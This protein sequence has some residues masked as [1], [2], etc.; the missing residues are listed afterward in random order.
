MS[1][2][3]CFLVEEAISPQSFT[4]KINGEDFKAD[5]FGS[6]ANI[7]EGDNGDYQVIIGGRDIRN[8]AAGTAQIIVMSF[9]GNSFSDLRDGQSFQAYDLNTEKGVQ[10]YFFDTTDTDDAIMFGSLFN[11]LGDIGVYEDIS[12]SL[13]ITSINRNEETISGDFSFEIYYPDEDVTYTI[14]DGKFRN[15]PSIEEGD[16]DL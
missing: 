13:R 12:S 11:S 4:A 1:L 5:R 14:T 16:D 15:L 3:A 10:C 8:L 9:S 6:A 2:Q 7:I